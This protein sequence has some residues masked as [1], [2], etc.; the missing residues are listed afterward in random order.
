MGIARHVMRSKQVTCEKLEVQS[1]KFKVKSKVNILF[2]LLVISIAAGLILNGKADA[3]FKLKKPIPE[4]CYD[5]HKELK[6]AQKDKFLHV[7]FKKGECITCH[8]SHVSSVPGLLD[9]TVGSI[10][11]GCHEDIRNLINAGRVH[12]VLREGDCTECHEAHSGNREHLLADE[13]KELC[14]K[15]HEYT[16]EQ[17]G[18]AYGCLPFKKG[19]CSACHDS[20]ASANNSLLRSEPNTLCK[21]CNAPNCKAEGISISHIVENLDCTSCHSGHGSE[22]RSALGPYGHTV[23]INKDCG[24][25]H[26]PIT[27]GKPV[28]VRLD[29]EELCF[30]CHK[31]EEYTYVKDDQHAKAQ[32]N[33]CNLCHSNHAS[34]NADL[35]VNERDICINCHKKTE[36]R[37]LEMERGLKTEECSPIKD[38]KCFECHI[39]G[40]S[41]QP[42]SFRGD[43]IEMCARC[44]TS[45][46][47]STHPVG[48][49]IIDPRDGKPVTCISCHSMHA[50][51]A[52]F[53]LTHDRNR[54]LC[55]QCHNK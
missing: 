39:P 5:C 34:N 19:E 8:N 41:D 15:C 26:N 16:R 46:H 12:N 29:G 20:H 21:E 22:N 42:L 37:T 2:I 14:V 55:I 6:D 30:S 33:Q 23:F 52:D 4:L 13:E 54:S 7:L 36:Q 3:S 38:R 43:G 11:L 24:Q 48:D 50:A 40:H 35:T 25:C 44:H 10:C 9:D 1:E 31:K 45:E 17:A 28:S 53:M 49:D 32:A 51:R 18:Q 27:S 47:S